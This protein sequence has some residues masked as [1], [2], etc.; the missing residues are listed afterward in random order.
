MAEAIDDGIE[1]VGVVGGDGTFSNVAGPVAAA[2]APLRLAL[3][4][5]GTGNDFVKNLGLAGGA[6]AMMANQLA[7]ARERFSP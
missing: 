2:G 4:P 7:G 6:P 1:T 5:S 3:I